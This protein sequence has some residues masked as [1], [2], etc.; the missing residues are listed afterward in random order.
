M[1]PFRSIA[2]ALA[3]AL[4]PALFAGAQQTHA[5]SSPAETDAGWVKEFTVQW[6]KLPFNPNVGQIQGKENA[7]NWDPRFALLLQSSF[8]QQQWFFED[9]DTL[10][11]LADVI[12]TY[13]GVPGDA[14]L[15]QDRFVTVDGCV[16]HV[17]EDR[18]MLWID[19]DTQPAQVIFVATDNVN[20]TGKGPDQMLWFF[21]SSKLDWNHIPQPFLASL[22]R[23]QEKLL[24]QDTANDSAYLDNFLVANLVQP[25][26]KIV[27]LSPSVLRLQSVI[28]LQPL[29]T[30]AK[31]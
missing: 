21:S 6:R 2:A 4:A 3:L 29:F 19:T 10:A 24:Q 1:I 7:L 9:N 25:N 13:V 16:P 17:C 11:P 26:G 31:Q 30:G 12:Q 5:A 22:H 23:W 14:L 20:G 18:G 27:T 28:G 15:D 8:H